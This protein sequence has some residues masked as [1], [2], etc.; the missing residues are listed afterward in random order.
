MSIDHNTARTAPPAQ[1]N[2]VVLRGAKQIALAV[3]LP[4][5][6]I[7]HMLSRGYLKT[8]RRIGHVWLA[9]RLRLRCEVGLE[10]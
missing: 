9:S 7:E 4:R 3:G 5:R 2:D 10:D 1:H 6:S 8:P